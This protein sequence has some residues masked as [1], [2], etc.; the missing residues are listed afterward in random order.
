MDGMD[1]MDGVDEVDGVDGGDGGSRRTGVCLSLLRNES[2]GRGR[3]GWALGR[4]GAR[5][6]LSLPS[7]RIPLQLTRGGRAGLRR[8]R[9]YWQRAY[10][11][12]GHFV[13]SADRGQ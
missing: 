5:V 10:F 2:L 3:P 9:P 4:N 12:R 1:R 6:W 13:N 8:N 7:V 11:G